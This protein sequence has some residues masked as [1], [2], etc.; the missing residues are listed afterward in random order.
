MSIMDIKGITSKYETGLSMAMDEAVI[1]R[2][3]V[4]S[5]ISS[6]R[7]ILNNSRMSLMTAASDTSTSEDILNKYTHNLRVNSEIF[8]KL[9][10]LQMA[11]EI[12]MAKFSACN[13]HGVKMESLEL[14]PRLYIWWDLL[15]RILT[16]RIE[17]AEKRMSYKRNRLK[18]SVDKGEAASVLQM[19]VDQIRMLEEPISTMKGLLPRVNKL[20]EE[21][22]D[23]KG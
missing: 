5:E 1:I 23:T 3:L 9:N 13:E 7:E 19:H 11:T 18:S 6:G 12:M 16:G 22:C 2:N 10:D 20:V 14:R 4:A 15:S 17:A 21:V 8:E